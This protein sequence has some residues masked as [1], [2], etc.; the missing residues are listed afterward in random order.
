M[1]AEVRQEGR[2]VGEQSASLC[3]WMLDGGLR[4]T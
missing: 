2:V 1:K 3:V 4:Y